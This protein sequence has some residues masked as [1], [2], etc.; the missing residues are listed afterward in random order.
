MAACI[1]NLANDIGVADI[2]GEAVVMANIVTV[3][4][5][6]IVHW[7]SKEVGGVV[8]KGVDFVDLL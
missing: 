4:S 1:L 7:F 5:M 3:V 6:K 2:T 8:F